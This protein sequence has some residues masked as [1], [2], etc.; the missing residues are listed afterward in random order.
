[1]SQTFKF[2]TLAVVIGG[3]AL[4][5]AAQDAAT[6]P[7]QVTVQEVT[8]TAHRL[9][10]GD[11]PKWEPINAGQKLD[12]NTVIRT[13]FR[14]RVVLAFAD[15]SV[16]V[17][18]RATKM[19]IGEFRKDGKATRT[20]LG[21]KYGSMRATVHKAA[22]PNDFT[23]AT[24]VATLAVTGTSGMIGLCGDAG[25]ALHGTSGTWNVAAGNRQR[26]VA[27]GERTNG[28]LTPSIQIAQN[29][30]DTRMVAVTG[31]SNSERKRLLNNGGGRG[32]F[33]FTQN[34]FGP[35][36]NVPSLLDN[37]ITINGEENSIVE[38]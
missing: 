5:A 19:G 32:I 23:V 6:T 33:S 24:P 7:L 30:R 15:N 38:H 14:T 37:S 8:G 17:V 11:P 35:I 22:G 10:G 28:R 2:L 13:G 3:A 1:M 31:L 9:A 25:L 29:N 18:E 26:N 34:P 16:V 27:A 12:E 20:R 4:A 36:L 21:L